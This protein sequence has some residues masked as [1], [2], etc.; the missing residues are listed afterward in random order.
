MFDGD[1]ETSLNLVLRV[2]DGSNGAWTKLQALYAPL[3]SHWCRRA[4]IRDADAGDIWQEVL[5][6]VSNHVHSFEK[7]QERGSFR[8]WLR[9]ITRTKIADHFRRAPLPAVGGSDAQNRL[10]LVADDGSQ[11]ESNAELLQ[12]QRIVFQRAI[13]LIQV[14]FE[15]R[16]WKAFWRTVI[17]DVPT[18]DV[19]AELQTTANAV[20]ISKA[21][22]LHRLR[23]EFGRLL[24]Q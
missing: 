13:Q 22:V 11:I 23:V 1:L 16:T 14:D 8:G 9:T 3:V 17:D 2:Q 24:D 20:R 10:E 4:G 6:A 19:A 12:E 7:K 18:S 5:L 15:E 21:R